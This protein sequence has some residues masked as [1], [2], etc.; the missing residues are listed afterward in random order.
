VQILTVLVNTVLA[1]VLIT[2]W[3]TAHP[4]GVAGAGLASSISVALGVLLL[5]LYYRRLEHYMS[6]DARLWWPQPHVWRQI[7][8]IGL[9][10]GAEFL[11]MFALFSFIYWL[12]R[13]FGAAAQ[14]GYGIGSRVMQAVFLPTM[15]LAFAVAPVA[16][17]NYGARQFAR[18]RETVRSAMMMGV[19]LMLVVTVLCQL[20]PQALVRPFTSDPAV[21]AVGSHYLRVISWNFAATGVIF[22]CSGA[23][24]AIGNT[25]P[26]MLSSASRVLSF[27]LPAWWWAQQQGFELTDVWYLSVMSITLQAILS[28]LLL[29]RQLR[30][31]LA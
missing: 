15:A 24:Q 23:F 10:A 11:M 19:G 30:L 2:G 17:Q 6:F 18:V 4:M 3:G 26:S 5:W 13:P 9:P 7:L 12:I 20:Q 29:R 28:L 27:V 31:R 14:A 25:V 21:I 22:S 8:A 16:G 1:P